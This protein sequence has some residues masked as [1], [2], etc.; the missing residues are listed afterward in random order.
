MNPSG[1]LVTLEDKIG[2][3]IPIF[4]ISKL[5]GRSMIIQLVHCEARTQAQ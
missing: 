4:Q 2:I 1:P 3:I 5:R